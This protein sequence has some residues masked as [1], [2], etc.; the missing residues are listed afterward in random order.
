MRPVRATIVAVEKAINI[1]Y[2]ESVFV[3][4]GTQHA[5]RTRHLSLWH[6]PLDSISPHY[7]INGKIFGE[8]VTDHIFFFNFLYN[9]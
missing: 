7:L 8:K 1:T 3:A 2:S 6:A 5:M 4:L 9:F